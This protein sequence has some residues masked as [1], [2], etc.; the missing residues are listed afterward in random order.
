MLT[1]PLLSAVVAEEYPPLVTTTDP[2]GV[3]FPA[4]PLTATTTE[5]DWSLLRV[6]DEGVTVIAGVILEGTLIV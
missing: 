4:P 3:G 1:L 5:S 6:V 2:L